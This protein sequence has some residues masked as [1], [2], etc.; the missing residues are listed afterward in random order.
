VQLG[1][2][3]MHPWGSSEAD[4]EKPDI[5]T[6]DLD[7]G[8][9]VGWPEVIAGARLLRRRLEGLGLK[10]YVKTSGS[11]GLHLVVPIRCRAGWE[12]AKAFAGAVARDLVRRR[13]ELFT[14]EMRKAKRQGRIFIDYLRNDRGATTVA[15]Y[16]TRARA[17]APVSTPIRWSELNRTMTS[18]RYRVDNLPR[19]LTALKNN[20]WPDFFTIRQGITR[21]MFRALG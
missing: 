4:L 9:D 21:A 18:D 17:G 3:E 2:L 11:K 12:E 16:S 10:S 14:A 19:R 1:V 8:P 5:L 6:F 7:P 20:P 13:P 15:A